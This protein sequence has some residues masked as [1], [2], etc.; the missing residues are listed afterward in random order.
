MFSKDEHQDCFDFKIDVLSYG[1]HF[2]F[3]R[4]LDTCDNDDYMIEVK[5]GSKKISN[6]RKTFL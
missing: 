2:M 3:K 1:F 5:C 4:K 6:F